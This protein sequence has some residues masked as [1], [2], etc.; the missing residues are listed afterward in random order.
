MEENLDHIF[1][2]C[3]N[4]LKFWDEINNKSTPCWRFIPA[5]YNGEN[6]N[7]IWED[8]KGKQYNSNLLWDNILPYCFWNIWLKRNDNTFRDKTEDISALNTIHQA[9]EY[10]LL[11]SPLS[12]SMNSAFTNSP[13]KWNP[14]KP[15]RYMLN[16]DGATTNNSFNGRIGGVIR[17]HNGDWIIGFISRVPHN[18]PKLAEFQALRMGLKLALE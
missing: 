5:S 11:A 12:T 17:N 7:K 2:K 1:F 4:A 15:G 18:N 14:P 8:S 13:V 6:W 3:T 9:T 16:T 10:L